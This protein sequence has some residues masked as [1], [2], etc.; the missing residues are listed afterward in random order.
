MRPT[1]TS[2]SKP[3]SAASARPDLH[4]RQRNERPRVIAIC[5]HVTDGVHDRRNS[6]RACA[7]GRRVRQCR[8]HQRSVSR[9]PWTAALRRAEVAHARRIAGLERT[10]DATARRDGHVAFSACIG[11]LPCK[12]GNTRLGLGR[13]L[14]GFERGFADDQGHAKRLAAFRPRDQPRTVPCAQIPC[15][16][17]MLRHGPLAPASRSSPALARHGTPTRWASPDRDG[18]LRLGSAV[19]WSNRGDPAR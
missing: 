19:G 16:A 9:C 8:R 7:A 13:S 17:R 10:E 18:W 6:L 3:S 12:P 5:R 15:S 1:T 2:S 11:V 14:D 4:V